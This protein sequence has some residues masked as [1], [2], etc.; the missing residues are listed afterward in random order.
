MRL[1]TFA[2][3]FAYSAI[4]NTISKTQRTKPMMTCKETEEEMYQEGE[5]PEPY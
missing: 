2:L 5:L 3:K 4:S 1:G